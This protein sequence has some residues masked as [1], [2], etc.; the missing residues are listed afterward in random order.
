MSYRSAALLLPQSEPLGGNIWR[1]KKFFFVYFVE[2][3]TPILAMQKFNCFLSECSLGKISDVVLKCRI[4]R[5][6]R[7]A[8]IYVLAEFVR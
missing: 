1:Q 8:V 3:S 5:L 4:H 2:L 7:E 6:L